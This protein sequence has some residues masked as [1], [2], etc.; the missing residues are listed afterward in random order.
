MADLAALAFDW[1]AHGATGQDYADQRAAFVRAFEPRFAELDGLTDVLVQRDYHAENL[2]WLP[3][4]SGVARVGLLDFQDAM[5]GHRAYDLVSLLQDARRDVSSQIETEMIGYYVSAAGVERTSFETAYAL[6][7]LQ[8]NL[9]IIGVFARLCLRDAKTHYLDMIPRVWAHMTRDL[10]RAC[11]PKLE[12]D[13]LADLP[14]PDANTLTILRQKCGTF[15][16]Q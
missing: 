5:K 6:L 11:L 8:R 2:L 4:R 12:T 16:D 14:V 10:E 3:S 13:L 7:G 1:Y 15:Q 9:R